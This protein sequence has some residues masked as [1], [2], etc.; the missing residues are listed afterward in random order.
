MASFMFVRFS[1][2]VVVVMVVGYLVEPSDAFEYYVGGKEGW[3][4]KPSKTFNHWASL[5]RFQV[6]D[7]LSNIIFIKFF[8]IFIYLHAADL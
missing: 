6:H 2:V 5:N 1:F 3:S 4:L 8:S 7:S